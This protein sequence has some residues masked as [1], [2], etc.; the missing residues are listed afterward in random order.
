MAGKR[1]SATA[2][3]GS[4]TTKDGS[5]HVVGIGNLRVIL[6]EEDGSWFAQALEIDYFAQGDSL[7]DVK[8]RFEQGLMMTIHENLKVFGNIEGVLISPPGEVWKELVACKPVGFSQVSVH[9]FREKQANMPLGFPFDGI[10]YLERAA[11]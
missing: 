6:T 10:Q 3:H 7:G 8:H 2:I 1:K 9:L 4:A 11:A 5:A